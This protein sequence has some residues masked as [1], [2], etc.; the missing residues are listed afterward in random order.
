MDKILK[1]INHIIQHDTNAVRVTIAKFVIDNQEFVMEN[2][3]AQ[4][5]KKCHVASSSITR[6]CQS[7][8]LSGLNE[9]KFIL[10]SRQNFNS[11]LQENSF[12]EN[13]D[14][15]NEIKVS[16]ALS[17]TNNWLNKKDEIIKLFNKDINIYIFCF[18]VAFFASKGFVQRMRG[19]GYK[20]F[21][22]DD[23]SSIQWYVD[24][25]KPQDLVIF[26]TLSGHNYLL[27][28]YAKTFFN[29]SYT[30]G[31][32]GQ[33]SSFNQVVDKTFILDNQESQLWDFYSIR[34]QTL[35]QFWDFLYLQLN[36]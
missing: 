21:L 23:V 15:Y 30:L 5:A 7:I 25:I 13:L 11:N 26:V 17:L 4:I 18:N 31:I 16:A 35:Q 20:I 10:K 32:L 29:K 27:E 9:L 1:K 3:T 22:E 28:S 36:N 8:G 2:E 19:I 12:E 24:N 33:D 34:S 6:F 14:K